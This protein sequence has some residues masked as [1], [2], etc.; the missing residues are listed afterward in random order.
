MRHRAEQPQRPLSHSLLQSQ[1][2]CARTWQH[3]LIS[4]LLLHSAPTSHSR[5]QEEYDD[6]ITPTKLQD[7]E[8]DAIMSTKPARKKSVSPK[9]SDDNGVSA[10]VTHTSQLTMQAAHY[11]PSFQFPYM[12][13]AFKDEN[14]P[15]RHMW[16]GC[17]SPNLP[18]EFI[19]EVRVLS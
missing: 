11:S 16:V 6:N 7:L 4:L 18:N 19:R 3:R 12:I 17:L 15:V 1:L 8:A 13:Y 5:K 14:L 2:H 9:K 10:L